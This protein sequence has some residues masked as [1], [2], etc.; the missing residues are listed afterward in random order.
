MINRKMKFMLNIL[1][2]SLA[3]HKEN[4]HI[5]KAKA[6]KGNKYNDKQ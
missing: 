1:S 2:K 3:N 5:Y 6:D 4:F